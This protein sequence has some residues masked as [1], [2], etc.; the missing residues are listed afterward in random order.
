MK[1][2]VN[3]RIS[4]LPKPQNIINQSLI[5]DKSINTLS[6]D[7]F[8]NNQTDQI[9]YLKKQVEI[10]QSRCN[11]L[12]KSIKENR[13]IYLLAIEVTKLGIYDTHSKV[14]D[15]PLKENWLV[16]LGYDPIK[17]KDDNDTW[18]S[19]IH[20]EDY[21]GISKQFQQAIDGKRKSLNME[22]RLRAANGDWRWIIESSNVIDDT[23]GNGK[24]RI[25]GTHFD[26]T[27]RK[28][29]EESER[30]Q[31]ELAEALI[32]CAS[33]FNSTLNLNKLLNLILINI[34]RIIPYDDADIWLMDENKKS[35]HPAYRRGNE[36]SVTPIYSVDFQII[37]IPV[38]KNISINRKPV[39]FSDI[40]TN[41]TKIPSRNPKFQSCICLPISFSKYLLGYLVIYSLN[42]D[43]YDK[44]QIDHLQA[45][46]NQAAT[47]IRNAQLYSKSIEVAAL[48][49][50]QRLAREMHDVISQTLFSASIKAETIPY[51]L[52]SQDTETIKQHINELYKL[53]RGALAEMR[54]MLMELRP[55]SIVNTD[56]TNLFQQ[57]IEGLS[58]RTTASIQFSNK[59]SGLLPPEVQTAF[60]R[61]AQ[62][63]FNNIV[64]HSKAQNVEI[65]YLKE[66]D[67]VKLSI[68]DNGCGFYPKKISSQQMGV[69][70]MRERAESVGAIFSLTTK[71]KVGTTIELKWYNPN[72]GRSNG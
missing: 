3:S 22:Y 34:S 18:L 61:I 71:T 48:E 42:K 37:D 20:P 9:E 40:L 32:A 55:N 8:M 33:I 11:E 24:K 51:L 15:S 56:L 16:R 49:E 14:E 38:F 60:F 6:T 59:G 69:K 13:E 31:R 39:Y 28:I 7:S 63:S 70:I 53:T 68:T 19:L 57:L 45:F 66:K 29:A 52:D 30:K 47:A 41:K 27:D 50:R 64:K 1:K 5:N 21:D 62:E 10:F 54:T 65:I 2:D 23:L 4:K 67:N 35:V 46:A 17:M 72:T 44:T 12:E 36:E 58:G 26:I 25:V 43:N